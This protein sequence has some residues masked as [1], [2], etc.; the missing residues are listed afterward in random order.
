MQTQ[1]SFQPDFRPALI[2]VKSCVNY[3][4]YR[5]E[6]ETIDDIL[7]RSGL[8]EIMIDL[9]LQ[10]RR[11][12]I[13]EDQ[14]R[15]CELNPFLRHSLVAW[16][17][18]L[19]VPLLDSRS[20]RDVEKNLADS[21]LHQWFCHIGNFGVVT[22]PSKSTIDRY[23]NWYDKDQLQQAFEILL[24]KAAANETHYDAALEEAVNILGFEMPSDLSEIW[25]DSTCLKPNIHFPVDW[26]L[27]TNV[28]RTLMKAVEIIRKHGLKNRMPADGPAAFLKRINQLSINMANSRRKKDSKKARKKILRQIKQLMKTVEKHARKHCELLETNLMDS[29]LSEALAAVVIARIKGVLEKLPQAI[30][31]AHERIIGERR[32][33]PED[34]LLSL[35]EPETKVIVRGKSGAEVEFGN[36]LLLGENREGLITCWELYDE[37]HNDDKLLEKALRDT[38]KNTGMPVSLMCGDRGF[39]NKKMQ[40]LLSEKDPAR[41]D[42][43]ASRSVVE[44][45]AQMKDDGFRESQR[46][47]SQT[48]GRI[49]IIKNVF[50]SGRSLSK[51]MDSRRQEL[52]WIMLSHNLRVLASKRI[53]E[54]KARESRRKALAKTG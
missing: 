49:G 8:D 25:F 26:V 50:M 5:E 39:A 12:R 37:V 48:E 28:V 32:V 23:K 10:R 33:A 31:Q 11:E 34:K 19:L 38:S 46:R 1:Y 45:E 29:D 22:S 44:F 2:P 53:A 52:S 16:R 20:V 24:Q 43:I 15:L 17:V 40:T 27:L 41:K 4:R 30:D 3:A 14:E 47:R 13:P 51:G 54:E 36:K 18:R 35:Y 7:R 21:S 9:A 42:H 6:L